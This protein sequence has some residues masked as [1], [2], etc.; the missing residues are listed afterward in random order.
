MLDRLY[1]AQ[2]FLVALDDQ[3]Q[4]HALDQQRQRL[5]DARRV[6]QVIIVQN[7]HIR[8]LWPAA[9]RQKR[10]A[11]DQ[12]GDDDRQRSGLWRPQELQRRSGTAGRE[13]VTGGADIGP[14]TDGVVILGVE[15]K[16]D[17]ARESRPPRR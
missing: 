3:G 7:E 16:P 9:G 4:R 10:Q 2:L 5:V 12:R 17:G 8:A 13:L 11:V 1:A 14:E 6:D 15:R